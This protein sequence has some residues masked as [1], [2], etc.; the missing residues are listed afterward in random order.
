MGFS[1]STTFCNGIASKLISKIR[2]ISENKSVEVD[3]L[4]DTGA[5]I[6]CI[7]HEVAKYLNL[8]PIGRQSMMSASNSQIVNT[9]CINVFVPGNVEFQGVIV[10][11]SNIGSQ[12]LGMLIG[13]DIISKGDFAVSNFNGTTVFTFRSPSKSTIDFVK[14]VVDEKESAK[15]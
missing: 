3:A 10:C 13:M 11:D 1:A 15:M 7:S 2:I 5:T 8:T 9:Y 12:G 6:S 14:E 4:W